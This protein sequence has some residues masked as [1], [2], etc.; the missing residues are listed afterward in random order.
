M[1]GILLS[2]PPRSRSHDPASEDRA[3]VDLRYTAAKE[4][5]GGF[6][7]EEDVLITGA[8]QITVEQAAA[9]QAGGGFISFGKAVIAGGSKLSLSNC[10]AKANHGGGFYVSKDLR[11]ENASSITVEHATA[12]QSG[13]GFI[14]FGKAV[15]AGGSKLSLSNCTAKAN[16]GGGFDVNKD[17]RVENSSSITVERATAGQAGGGFIS[18]GK[19]VIA[20][21]SKLS[22]S[23]C[24]AKAKHGGGFY[25]SKDLRV[26][27]ASSITVEHATAGQSGGGFISFGQAVIA[28]NSKLSLS[29]CTAKAKHGGGFDVDKDLR[30]EDASSITVEHATAGKSGGGFISFGQ[31]VVSGGSK[32]SLSNCTALAQHGGGFY[33][34]KDLRVEN[35]SSITVE[36][37]TAGKSGGGFISSGKA[38]IAGG[39]RVSLSNCT[40][41]AQHGGGFYVEKDLR[42]ENSFTVE[43]ATA[44]KSGGGFISSGKAVIA[45]G[46]RVSLSHCKAGA[47][48]GGLAAERGLLLS[49][50]SLL[51]IT[52][53]QAPSGAAAATSDLELMSRS[54]LRAVAAHGLS[55]LH[56]ASLRLHQANISLEEVASRHCF[57]IQ[58][59]EACA[60]RTWD[61]LDGLLE[62]RASN[63]TDGLVSVKG[64]LD[65]T[66]ELSGIRA[67]DWMGPLIIAENPIV[68]RDAMVEYVEAVEEELLLSSSNFSM[69]EGSGVKVSCKACPQGVTFKATTSELHVI[70]SSSLSCPP[71]AVA[72]FGS[73]AFCD[74]GNSRVR[75]AELADAQT[76]SI[77]ETDAYCTPCEAHT[78][79]RGR[80]HGEGECHQCPLYKAWSRGAEDRCGFLPSDTDLL[81]FLV[82]LSATLCLCACIFLVIVLTPLFVVD[83]TFHPKSAE[84]RVQGPLHRLPSFLERWVLRDLAFRIYDTGLPC[85]GAVVQASRKF[86]SSK[87]LVTGA[88]VPFSCVTSKGRL[89]PNRYGRL[90]AQLILIVS[91]VAFVC[92]VAVSYRSGNGHVQMTITFLYCVV[93]CVAVSLVMY[94]VMNRLLQRLYRRTPLQAACEEYMAQM[95]R[96]G[97]QRPH[98]SEAGQGL[99]AQTLCGLFTHFESFLLQRNMHYVVGNLVLPLT[100]DKQCSFVT[101][102]GNKAVDFFVSHCWQTSF[103][104]FVT[105]ICHHA[106]FAAQIDEASPANGTGLLPLTLDASALLTT[107]WICSFANNQCL[108][109]G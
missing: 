45:G 7:V 89:S 88:S 39:S 109:G 20:G 9:G 97:A 63:I 103:Q 25:V 40:A 30:V 27:N 5:G 44:G 87:L 80:S 59:P 49:S 101:L 12:G 1:Q 29:N 93:P 62:V 85:D 23:N 47:K 70:S 4:A 108:I 69:A 50:T 67:W 81:A 6:Y 41:L 76:V 52:R 38:V 106:A 42:V 14:S 33:V 64:C 58:S 31:A 91:L 19:A 17:L 21:N 37:A 75:N 18:F 16:Q 95:K 102:C 26:E 61:V 34:E 35:S 54:A 32:L 94:F 79:F 104:H 2:N 24:T 107:Y 72:S 66:L 8:S 73:T 36:H 55:A 51:L 77:Y 82:A 53:G 99:E 83:A 28:G 86:A 46:S 74:C 56:A 10:M 3:A 57:R 48:G 105:S 92:L 13:G 60:S 15:I 11:V 98:G 43:H 90:L 68:L 84:M 71:E 96:E 65:E 100:A 78:E 22:L